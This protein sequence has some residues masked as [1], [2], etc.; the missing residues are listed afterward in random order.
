MASCLGLPD[1]GFGVG[2][3]SQHFEAV[4]RHK[5]AVDWFE[6]ITENVLDDGGWARQVLDRVA[7]RYPIVLHGVSLSIGS[8]DPLDRSY[9]ARLRRL[10][11]ETRAQ[12][13]SDHLC[14]TG[15]GG[16]NTHDLLPMPLT[17]E[18]LIHTIARVQAVQEQLARPLILENP[19]T[20]L[21][22]ASS[23]ISEP[24]FLGALTAHTGCG[25]LLDVNNVYVS[26]RN[27]GFDA[28][29]Y[30]RAIPGERIVQIHLAGHCD[31]GSHVIDTHD[32]PVAPAVW[33][34]YRRLLEQVGCR[35]TLIEWDARI[36]PFDEL[37]AQ[38][39]R[40]R[41]IALGIST[42]SAGSARSSAC[43]ARGD[44]ASMQLEACG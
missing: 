26:S 27:H 10:A 33:T 22:F 35:S 25:L 41:E 24:E 1:L 11:D 14:F 44:A 43:G 5:P 34:L 4:L 17:E 39:L 8:T 19:S 3:R 28:E 2:L 6:V 7:S 36:P 29:A 31:R 23:T 12:W 13:V 37:H 42:G 21:E 15:V 30:L 40:A 16:T 20:Y 38:A 32:G 9:L 18:S